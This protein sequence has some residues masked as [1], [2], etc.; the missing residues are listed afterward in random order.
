MASIIKRSRSGL[1]APSNSPRGRL[2]F[3]FPIALAQDPAESRVSPSQ[4]TLRAGSLCSRRRNGG[5]GESSVNSSP[6]P[7]LCSVEGTGIA[8]LRGSARRLWKSLDSNAPFDRPLLGSTVR[9]KRKLRSPTSTSRDRLEN[10]VSSQN[11]RLCSLTPAPSEH[12]FRAQ[13]REFFPCRL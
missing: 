6:E 11:T 13:F 3:G 2:R 5:G 8:P 4:L 7:E 1:S 12:G 10:Q 9:Y